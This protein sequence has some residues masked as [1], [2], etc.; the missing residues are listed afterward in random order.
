MKLNLAEAYYNDNQVGKAKQALKDV[1]H[2]SI[3]E[4]KDLLVI[5]ELQGDKLIKAIYN[6]RRAEFVG[7]GLR[8]IDIHRRGEAFNKRNGVYQPTDGGY[9]WPIPTSERI[10]NNLIE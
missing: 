8:S 1:R 5:D 10:V 4:E 3:P 6:E 9:I 2:R 7:E